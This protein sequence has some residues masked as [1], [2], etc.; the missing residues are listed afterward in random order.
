MSPTLLTTAVLRP[1]GRDQ[2]EAFYAELSGP[3]RSEWV[4][5][6]RRCK[7]R[8][9]AVWLTP[10]PLQAVVLVE[11]PDPVASAAA[12]ETSKDPF[13]VWFRERLGAL[14]ELPAPAAPIFD[15]KPRPGTWRG[16]VGWRPQ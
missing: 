8:R 7:V 11:G 15:S 14:T 12:L 5:S 6:Q 1:G 4:Q 9:E 2:W 13:D 10:D 3:R 16:L